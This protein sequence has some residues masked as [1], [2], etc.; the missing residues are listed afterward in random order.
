MVAVAAGLR[1]IFRCIVTAISLAIIYAVFEVLRHGE[2]NPTARALLLGD[3]VLALALA[4]AA[5][6]RHVVAT[7]V[8]VCAI[9]ILAALYLFELWQRDPLDEMLHIEQQWR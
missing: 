2:A 3:G 7:Y 8:Q 6:S 5:W 1:L 4:A 9:P